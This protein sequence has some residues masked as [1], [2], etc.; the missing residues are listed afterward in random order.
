MNSV[1][2]CSKSL[3]SIVNTL[4]AC[5]ASPCIEKGSSRQPQRQTPPMKCERKNC[6]HILQC[7]RNWKVRFKKSIL[8]D[9]WELRHRKRCAPRQSQLRSSQSV[10]ENKRKLS[11]S[12]LSIYKLSA[13]LVF[14]LFDCHPQ[15]HTCQRSHLMKYWC[16][17]FAN[18]NVPIQSKSYDVAVNLS[19][20]CLWEPEFPGMKRTGIPENF[21]AFN[22][23][24]PVSHCTLLLKMIFSTNCI[25]MEYFHCNLSK[26][27]PSPSP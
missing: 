13:H 15:C 4:L 22:L 20:T 26:C 17:A 25:G 3:P 8:P 9:H 12:I 27:F 23:G 19:E 1:N 5:F 6:I 18:C 24:R 21:S 16:S 10:P 2:G 14:W 7:I 11:S